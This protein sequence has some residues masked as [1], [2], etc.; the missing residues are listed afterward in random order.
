MH[1]VLCCAEQSGM[2][3]HVSLVRQG[4]ALHQRNYTV[5]HGMGVGG[6][7]AIYM[8]HPECVRDE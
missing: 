8:V 4:A 5:S 1:A 7:G 6:V 3:M 2:S